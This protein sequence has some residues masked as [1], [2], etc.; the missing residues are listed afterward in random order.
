MQVRET[1]PFAPV[2][3]ESTRAIGYSLEAAIADIIDNSIAAK[4][5]KVQLFFFPVDDAY[6]CILDNGSGMDDAQIDV[7]M[8]Y[9]SKS[10]TDMRDASDLGRY[11]LGLKTASLSQCRVL[12]VVS[13]QGNTII[14]RRWDLDYV[15]ETGK[16]SLLV[17]DEDDLEKV[18]HI[19]DLKEQENGTLV[20][21]QNL[22]RL[23]MGEV[24]YEKSLGRKMDDVRQHLGLV[25]HRY[26][27]GEAGIKRLEILFNGVKIKAADPFLLKKSTQAMDTE[28][29]IIRGK[30]ILVKPYIL[31]HI[32]KM[33][34]EEKNQLGG[35]E[36]IRKQQGFYVYRNKRLLIWGTWFRMMRQG[37]LSKLARVMVDIPNDLDD[38]WTLDIKKSHARPALH[39]GVSLRS[40]RSEKLAEFVKLLL[41]NEPSAAAAVYSELSIHYPII[42][43]R[44]L[45]KAKE[46]IRKKAR[47]TERY[48]LLASSEGKRL[49]GIGIWVPSVIN[50]VGWFLN[51]KDNVDSPYFLEVAASEFKVQGLE[52]DYSILAWDADLRRSGEG[53]DYFKFRGT[54]WNHVNNMQQQKY[55]KNAYRVLMTRARQGMIIFVPS[56][57]DPEDDPT[58]DSAYY[59]DIYKYLRS[60]G[61]KELM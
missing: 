44:D 43:T 26:L 45:D 56:G 8:Q 40:F 55:L 46:W 6:V 53:F 30:K 47:G 58:R 37:D 10:P 48:G 3:M 41:D 13:K 39:L 51:E 23:L 33:T 32:S 60:C 15:I 9:G 11:G 18:P 24:D 29:L 61:I 31:P 7:A 20:V 49:R 17:L 27:S 36:G 2:L 21:W 22:D 1:P 5:G 59:D 28:T 50:H 34:E 38:L 16:W 35:K 19:A 14:G 25:F 4:A 52:I 42:L 12:T 54:R 57:T